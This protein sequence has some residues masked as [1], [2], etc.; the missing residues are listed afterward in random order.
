MKYLNVIGTYLFDFKDVSFL[1]KEGAHNW[2]CRVEEAMLEDC[3]T[4]MQLPEQIWPLVST[5]FDNQEPVILTFSAEAKSSYSKTLDKI[6]GNNDISR[7]FLL[8][9]GLKAKVVYNEDSETEQSIIEKN[10]SEITVHG[11]GSVTKTHKKG[12]LL[13]FEAEIDYLRYKDDQTA[14]SLLDNPNGKSDIFFDGTPMNIG[15]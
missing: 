9:P 10:E 4:T 2:L 13:I 1:T 5:A 14:I 15:M 3:S 7:L 8:L 6:G 12:T 11:D